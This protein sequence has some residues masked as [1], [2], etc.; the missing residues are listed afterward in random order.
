[1]DKETLEVRHKHWENII[2]Q[3][4][5]RPQGQTITQW[6]AEHGISSR[7]YYYWQKHLRQEA[8][9][10]MQQAKL[11]EVSQ[12]TEVTFAELPVPQRFDFKAEDQM[13]FHA[14]AVIQTCRCTVAV[15]N[16]ISEQ[17]LKEILEVTREC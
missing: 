16:S 10:Q 12:D 13:P 15:S 7:S 5:A 14:D 17:L 2:K 8:Y 9:S 1:M 4:H 11:P 3:C 6:L